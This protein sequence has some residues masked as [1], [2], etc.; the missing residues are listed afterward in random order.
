MIL[1]SQIGSEPTQNKLKQSKNTTIF[2]EGAKTMYNVSSKKEAWKLVDKLFPTDYE[3]DVVS[4]QNAGYDIYKS[5]RD[6]AN[7]W[8]SDLGCGLEINLYNGETIRIWIEEPEDGKKLKNDVTAA[9]EECERLKN[10]A[11]KQAAK[12]IE[13]ENEIV[14]LGKVIEKLKYENDVLN[15]WKLE[16]AYSGMT[17]EEY[18]RLNE[19]GCVVQLEEWEAVDMVS[20]EFGFEKSKIKIENMVEVLEKNRIGQRRVAGKEKRVPLFE[21]WDWNY[22]LFSV[23]GMVY[24]MVNGDLRINN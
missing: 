23:S 1:W 21:A 9:K 12:N 24:E 19:D 10:E 5:T 17:T 11:A 8:I 4:T 7:S 3:L 16:G 15:C 14:E 2:R 13:L 20:N 18:A 22:I 6:G